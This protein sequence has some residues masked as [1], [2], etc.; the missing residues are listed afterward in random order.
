MTNY[1]FDSNFIP[2]NLR[3]IKTPNEAPEASATLFAQW[4]KPASLPANLKLPHC[5][6]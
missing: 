6:R 4:P 3:H 1:P 5:L 2:D